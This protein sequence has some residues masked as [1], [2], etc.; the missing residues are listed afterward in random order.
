MNIILIITAVILFAVFIKAH[1]RRK[2]PARAAIANMVLGTLLLV[3]VSPLI[4]SAINIYTMFAA[5]TLGIPGVVVVVAGKVL[6][7]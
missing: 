6:L 5:L 1:S 2:S 7:G 4:D 3:L